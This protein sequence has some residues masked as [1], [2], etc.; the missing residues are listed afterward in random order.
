M[1]IVELKILVR[2][3]EQAYLWNTGSMRARSIEEAIGK[4][5]EFIDQNRDG[6]DPKE[7]SLSAETL[8]HGVSRRLDSRVYDQ[9]I[10]G[11]IISNNFPGYEVTITLNR[12]T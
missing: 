5:K 6:V 11:D 9:D 12:K 1:D 3:V 2:A 4:L 8:E 10:V 7:A